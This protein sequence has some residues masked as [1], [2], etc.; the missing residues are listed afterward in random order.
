MCPKR[1]PPAL[2]GGGVPSKPGENASGTR[3]KVKSFAGSDGS[4]QFVGFYDSERQ[5]D[6]SYSYASD[7]KLRCLPPASGVSLYA[8]ANCSIPVLN[9]PPGS[10]SALASYVTVTTPG[11]DACSVG[12]SRLFRRGSAFTPSG[13]V[14]W[15]VP[16]YSA[17]P[18][19][20]SFIYYSMAE[21]VAPS[22]FVDAMPVTE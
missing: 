20:S 16:S 8:D 2:L 9:V 22:S 15:K 18:A 12:A 21:E 5:E 13:T 19:T 10:C 3:I 7:G 17:Y 1:N 14:Y 4:K 6:C 11:A